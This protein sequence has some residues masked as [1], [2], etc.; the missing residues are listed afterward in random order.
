MD[1]QNMLAF[2][3]GSADDEST[4]PEQRLLFARKANWLRIV[5]RLQ[6]T[7]RVVRGLHGLESSEKRL[8][9]E[10]DSEAE[11]FSPIRLS[12]KPWKYADTEF[13]NQ[14]TRPEDISP[15][16]K[17]PNTR[18]NVVSRVLSRLHVSG[19]VHGSYQEGLREGRRRVHQR[20]TTRCQVGGQDRKTAPEGSS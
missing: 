19:I 15:K 7:G 8:V 17:A 3:E 20:P 9:N 5:S 11:L 12:E 13:L 2:Y 18:P 10:D 14:Q 4:A 6:A 1:W 16:T